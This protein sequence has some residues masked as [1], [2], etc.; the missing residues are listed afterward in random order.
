MMKNYTSATANTRPQHQS[1]L[2]YAV[3][4]IKNVQSKL[5]TELRRPD[6]SELI[7]SSHWR[8][9]VGR[10]LYR[11]GGR[12]GGLGGEVP[13]GEVAA[14][15]RAGPVRAQPGVDAVGVE[16][17]VARGELP[18]HLAGAH[19]LQA[20]R[21]QQHGAAALRRGGQRLV[22]ERR[23]QADG[24]VRQPARAAAVHH[25]LHRRRRSAAGLLPLRSR[26]RGTVQRGR[27]PTGEAEQDRGRG[28]DGA[29][30]GDAARR[31]GQ[32]DE[33]QQR[34]AG[35]HDAVAGTALVVAAVLGGA[36]HHH[37][38]V[39][40]QHVVRSLTPSVLLAAGANDP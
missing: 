1:N 29:G 23:Q 12:R 6:S 27:G 4:E 13:L 38:W 30:P 17:V 26:R 11:D 5:R 19:V 18:H 31:G 36:R 7:G 15:E 21:A 9:G 25:Q 34:D 37:P 20:H 39:Q 35:H 10:G 22:R 24:L 3:L 33:E 40:R 28:G 32:H 16:E 14:A 8:Q 2:L